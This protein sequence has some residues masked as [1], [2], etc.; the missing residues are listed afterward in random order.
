MSKNTILRAMTQD[1]SARVHVI[2]ST[3]MVNQAI[4]YHKPSPTATAALGRVLTV[5]SMMG[6]MLGEETDSIT[7]S[8]GGDGPAGRIIA[9]SDWIGNVRGYMQHPTAD[10]PLKPSGKLDVGGLVGDGVVTV[11]KD[12]GGEIPE[13][14]SVA[15]T[16]GEIAED[17]TTY[18]AESEQVPT[19]CAL[20]VLV[21]T[22]HSCRAAGG[23]LIQL[24]PF[25]DEQTV[26]AIEKNIPALANV[27]SLFEKG[28][29]NED[30]AKIALQGIPFDIF[31]EL[32]VDYVCNCSRE[33][34]ERALISLG[35]D[36]L[37][38]MLAEQLA[39]GKDDSLEVNC[40]FCNKSHAFTREDIQKMF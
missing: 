37:L 4:E 20:G 6:C 17:I 30:I 15:L 24:L 9:V 35:K 26:S 5:T 11:V 18:Y 34:M 27:S 29:S 31:D 40:R 36:E 2:R 8:F 13:S 39:E 3:D 38:K 10:L 14:G 19:L 28:F 1:G 32:D 23:I 33:R 25:A 16:S 21:D 7:V 12:L 22:D